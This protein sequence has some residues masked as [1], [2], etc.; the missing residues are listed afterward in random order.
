MHALPPIA[1]RPELLHTEGP[2]RGYA[3]QGSTFAG[4]LWIGFPDYRRRKARTAP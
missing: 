3:F 1:Y 4:I 2:H